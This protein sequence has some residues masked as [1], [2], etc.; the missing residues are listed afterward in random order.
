[1]EATE[2]DERGKPE[3]SES[4]FGDAGFNTVHWNKLWPFRRFLGD[5]NEGFHLVC[6]LNALSWFYH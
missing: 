4:D 6:G 3:Q 2:G 1:M 5:F